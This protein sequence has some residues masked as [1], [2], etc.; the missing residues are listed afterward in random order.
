MQILNEFAVLIDQFE[1]F[2]QNLRTDLHRE[3]ERSPS[4]RY[5]HRRENH[6]SIGVSE[7]RG[8]SLADAL[9]F[10]VILT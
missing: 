6:G 3:S 1:K 7:A 2:H 9:R 10:L 5:L 8:D 4:R